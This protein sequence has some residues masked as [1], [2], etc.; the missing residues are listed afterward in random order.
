MAQDVGPGA[1]DV[2]PTGSKG[3]TYCSANETCGSGYEHFH[4][5]LLIS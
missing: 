2:A 1:A 5:K 3:L 4:F